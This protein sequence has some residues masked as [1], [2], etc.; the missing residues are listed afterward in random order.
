MPSGHRAQAANRQSKAIHR[1]LLIE[2]NADSRETLRLLIELWGHEVEVA[3]DGTGGVGK[4]IDWHPNVA[5]VDI[6]LPT[7]SGFQ[8]ARRLR[9]TLGQ[10]VRLIALTANCRAEDRRLAADAGFDHFMAKPADL[11]ELSRLV[12]LPT[13][14][15][16]INERPRI[17]QPGNSRHSQ[18]APA[19]KP[20]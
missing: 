20:R 12:A 3:E 19:N 4:A 2:D 17:D 5:V 14:P 16:S 8:V 11:A 10:S 6:G 18:K 9:Q 13:N 1:V 15:V 7:L